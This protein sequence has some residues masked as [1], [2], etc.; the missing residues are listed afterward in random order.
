M[1]GRAGQGRAGQGN[2][3]TGPD[4]GPAFQHCAVNHSN[5]CL[6]MT[7]EILGYSK[8]K[9]FHQYQLIGHSK[10]VLNS[11]SICCYSSLLIHVGIQQQ[12]EE[13]VQKLRR[14]WFLHPPHMLVARTVNRG[15]LR[16]AISPLRKCNQDQNA[17]PAHEAAPV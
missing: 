4:H 12:S 8:W 9:S 13:E 10:P 15:N 3:S 14:V 1:L 17:L 16:R 7:R 5:S 11:H 2:I 6:L